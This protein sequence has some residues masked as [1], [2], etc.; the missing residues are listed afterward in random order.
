MDVALGVREWKR[1]F[2]RSAVSGG[3]ESYTKV[4][5]ESDV[6][7]S[8]T[9]LAI[10]ASKMSALEPITL[11]GNQSV[12][13]AASF[14][15]CRRADSRLLSRRLLFLLLRLDCFRAWFCLECAVAAFRLL[16]C[17]ERYLRDAG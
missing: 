16:A 7:A 10:L 12:V 4:S 11:V 1:R 5:S 6:L 17:S 15:T 14:L 2:D 13:L 3:L 9:A 8:S